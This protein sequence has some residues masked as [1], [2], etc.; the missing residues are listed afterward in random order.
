MRQVFGG[1]GVAPKRKEVHSYD[2][3]SHP[4][5][6]MSTSHIVVKRKVFCVG[7]IINI[8]TNK[9]GGVFFMKKSTELFKNSLNELKNL[10][11][12]CVLGVLGALSIILYTIT[13]QLGNFIQLGFDPV[14]NIFSSLLFGPVTGAIFGGAMDV[15]NFFLNPRGSFCPGLT[16]NAVLSGLFLG[17]MLYKKKPTAKRL[18]PVLLIDHLVINALLGTFWLVVTY[19]NGM[20]AYFPTRL[21]SNLV[22]PFVETGIILVLH[23]ALERSGLLQTL[24]QPFGHKNK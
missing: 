23:T 1:W 4:L 19:G 14:C 7:I 15:L 8:T 6:Q 16:F 2:M 3:V 18:I 12:L 5:L 21:I 24:R 10:K 13:I 9:Y 22:K 11:V 17:T 20:L